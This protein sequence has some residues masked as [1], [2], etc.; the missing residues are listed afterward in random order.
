MES[1]AVKFL[2]ADKD[3]E[4]VRE[5]E[6]RLAT[7]AREE[8]LLNY[9]DLACGIR[10]TL[11][12]KNRTEV[13]EIDTSNW[14]EHERAIIGDYLGFISYRTYREAG[15]L[16]SALAITKEE[17]V[18]SKPFFNFCLGTRRAQAATGPARVLVRASREG[19][20]LVPE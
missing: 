16:A 6:S 17:C 1:G 5:L 3:A 9:S 19:A 18:P 7:A 4:A 11:A 14:S 10:F 2:W 20:G 13:V 8:R 12:K 15:F